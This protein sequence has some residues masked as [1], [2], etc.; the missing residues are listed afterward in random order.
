ME[1]KKSPKVDLEN[2]KSLFLQIGF[3][4]SLSIVLIAFEWTSSSSSRREMQTID[5][6]AVEEDITP[7]TRNEEKPAPPPS[8][9]K[10][11]DVLNIVEDNAK[12]DEELII[13]D[14]E[15]D[16]NTQV[17]VTNNVVTSPS[18][19]EEEEI[20]E[21]PVFFIVEE[22]PEFPGGPT[23]ITKFIT[24]NIKYPIIAQE[25]GVQGR[26]YVTFVVNGKGEVENVKIAR[27]VDPSLDREAVRVVETMPKWKPGKQRNKPVKVSF[28]IPVNFVL[29]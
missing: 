21:A 18:K 1:V 20:E 6:G 9:A 28:T 10:V 23:E 11:L 3:I 8:L 14:S 7:I 27:G 25:N 19:I 17:E 29:Q 16:Q 26:V 4:L 24:H 15:S 2:K 12:I 13:Q 22:M 5:E